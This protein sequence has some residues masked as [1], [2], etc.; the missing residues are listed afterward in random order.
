[1]C[2][3]CVVPFTRGRER[4]RDPESIVKEAKD[5]FEMGYREVTLLGQNVDSYIWAGGGLKKEILT[6]EQKAMSVNTKAICVVHYLG[7]PVAMDMVMQIAK[8]NNLFVVEDCA[9]ALGARVDGTHV[10]LLG[11]FGAF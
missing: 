6:E 5:A 3:F 10:G 1:M 7:V 4:S 11:D 8:H 9:L 2:S